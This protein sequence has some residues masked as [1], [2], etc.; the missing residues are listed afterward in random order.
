LDDFEHV[1]FDDWEMDFLW[2][3]LGGPP[4]KEP[5]NVFQ[6]L[7]NIHKWLYWGAPRKMEYAAQYLVRYR[8]LDILLDVMQA[9]PHPNLVSVSRGPFPS[10]TTR[11]DKIHKSLADWTQ[12]ISR[13]E[14]MVDGHD[15]RARQLVEDQNTGSLNMLGWHDTGHMQPSGPVGLPSTM[16]TMGLETGRA[17]I[18]NISNP[19]TPEDFH[20]PSYQPSS[21]D[22]MEMDRPPSSLSGIDQL[23]SSPS[24]TS[25]LAE[26]L[27]PWMIVLR[28]Q[29]PEISQVHLSSLPGHIVNAGVLNLLSAQKHFAD[30]SMHKVLLNLE[31]A[32]FALSWFAMVCFLYEPM[33]L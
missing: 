25:A 4:A 14:S 11:M 19:I 9:E 20:A 32:A 33:E 27:E 28:Q 3:Y 17:G 6:H 7:G 16:Q 2:E 24:N 23:Q 29:M 12:C 1:C 10:G 13:F 22:S 18:G 30:A 31:L 21:Y 15:R 8:V 5:I 26:N